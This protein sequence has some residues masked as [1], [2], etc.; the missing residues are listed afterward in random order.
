MFV[1]N[2]T[3]KVNHE[4]LDDWMQWQKTIQIPDI[5]ATG[6]F[7]DHRF[8]ELMNLEEDDGRTFV[9]QF[10]AKSKSD[11]NRYQQIFGVSLRHRAV[12]KWKD[13]VVSFRTLLKNVE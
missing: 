1:Y 8:Y 5:L 10:L 7:Y 13:S 2:I 9:I 11:Y 3:F 4:C 6:C 12:E